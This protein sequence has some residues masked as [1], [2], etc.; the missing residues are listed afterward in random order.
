MEINDFVLRRLF[1]VYKTIPL[2][3]IAWNKSWNRRFPANRN[4][5]NYLWKR[6]V[7][8]SKYAV[9]FSST[10][11]EARSLQIFPFISGERTGVC[12]GIFRLLWSNRIDFVKANGKQNLLIWNS[13]QSSKSTCGLH[14]RLMIAHP[15]CFVTPISVFIGWIK[16]SSRVDVQSIWKKRKKSITFRK[17]VTTKQR[18]EHRKNE[19]SSSTSC[20]CARCLIAIQLNRLACNLSLNG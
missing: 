6:R 20:S 2:I 10:Q 3:H 18:K 15:S 7:N 5:I 4:R 14:L 16:M 19:K 17:K 11:S 13:L 12:M 1:K 8:S 9:K